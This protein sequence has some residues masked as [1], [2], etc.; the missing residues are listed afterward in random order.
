V[1]IGSLSAL[2]FGSFAAASEVDFAIVGIVPP[3]E[4]FTISPAA[5]TSDDLIEFFD[6]Y[7]KQAYTNACIAAT[8]LGSPQIAVNE[9]EHQI[10]ISFEP[11]PDRCSNQ[12][13]LVSG[14]RGNFGPLSPGDWT[15]ETPLASH[16]FTVVPEPLVLWA[17]GPLIF[18]VGGR[19]RLRRMRPG[20]AAATF[21]S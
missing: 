6:P 2:L 19:R 18:V 11:F 15:Y 9:N 7:D 5:P 3:K 10:A 21:S 13:L 4:V 20:T 12:G 16:T 8:T 1:I 17:A 14:L